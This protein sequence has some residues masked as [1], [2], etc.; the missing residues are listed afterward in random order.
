MLS[1]LRRGVKYVLAT[2]ACGYFL[3][4]DRFERDFVLG[5]VFSECSRALVGEGLLHLEVEG[6]N[7]HE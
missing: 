4:T 1:L 3:K 2:A 5:E 6:L 7:F